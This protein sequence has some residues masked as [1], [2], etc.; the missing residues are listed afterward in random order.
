MKTIEIKVDEQLLNTIAQ[1][2][3][4]RSLAIPEIF[5]RS[6]KFVLK[7]KRQRIIDQ[8]IEKAYS[9]PRVREEFNREMQ[10]WEDEQVWID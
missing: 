8:Q 7:L 10:D 9:D 6:M 1:D 2:E 3:E 5:L 4:F